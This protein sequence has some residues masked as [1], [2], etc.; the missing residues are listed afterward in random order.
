MKPTHTSERHPILDV[1][2]GF[3]LSGI[4]LINI[5]AFNFPGSPP[6]YLYDG[7]LKEKL[8]YGLLICLIES[9]FFCLFSLLF[10]M[11]FYLQ[12]DR[13]QRREGDFVWLFIRRNVVLMLFGILH[14]LF[15]W[16]G[17]ILL[18]YSIVGFILLKFRKA[19]G[20]LLI[21][22]IKAL[23]TIPTLIYVL[24]ICS[25]EIIRY[26]E[27]IGFKIAKFEM[28]FP[29]FFEEAKLETLQAI[30]N[31]SYG[32]SMSYRINAYLSVI[33]LLI[34]RIPVVLMMFLMGF[35]L[36][37][38]EILFHLKSNQMFIIQTAQKMVLIG[39]L[40]SLGICVIYFEAQPITA[41][42]I[43]FL[44]QSIAGPLLSVGYL[45]SLSWIYIK[46]PHWIV[47]KLWET[48]GRT[49]LSVYIIQSLVCSI[50]FNHYG[51]GWVGHLNILA[52]LMLALLI[53]LILMVCS[54]YWLRKFRFGLL[55]WI[56]R[57]LTYQN[58]FPLKSSR[59]H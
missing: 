53:N 9:K 59:N 46:Y 54:Y 32:S 10:G 50:L 56:W 38:K 52:C 4:L 1:L 21:K 5:V 57:M 36:G 45:M 6:G 8:G 17:D 22:W 55:E 7:G 16:E 29:V 58:I 37:Q 51:F 26:V 43:L 40:L 28:E 19:E 30:Q 11:G 42:L 12:L 3:A 24:I 44:N 35:Y 14:I 23:I 20:H 48:Y 18:I 31:N 27:P 13:S 49:A 25:L 39:L 47:F 33:F 2:R 34:T 41:L 15:I